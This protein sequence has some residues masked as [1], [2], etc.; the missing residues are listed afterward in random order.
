MTVDE[1]ALI[2][3]TVLHTHATCA[4]LLTLCR[5]ESDAV[6]VLA[7]RRLA[8]YTRLRLLD[9][10]PN[11]DRWLLYVEVDAAIARARQRRIESTRRRL[12]V[13]GADPPLVRG[14]DGHD[15]S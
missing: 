8:H 15:P 2:E 7:A 3:E 1:R 14:A 9:G 13:P 11:Y 4:V 6:V 10:V 12:T 5:D